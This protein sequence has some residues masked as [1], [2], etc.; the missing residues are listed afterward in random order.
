[1]ARDDFS[2]LWDRATSSPAWI[3]IFLSSSSWGFA[4]F[5]IR[6]RMMDC[7]VWRL[8]AKRYFFFS[9]RMSLIPPLPKGNGTFFR[10]A[11]QSWPSNIRFGQTDTVASITVKKGRLKGKQRDRLLNTFL[12]SHI[13]K[14][15]VLQLLYETNFYSISVTDGSFFPMRDWY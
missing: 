15:E 9:L 7:W 8:G 2:P 6:S 12:N 3:N 5:K 13:Q 11:F 4:Q 14:E 1:M 10:W